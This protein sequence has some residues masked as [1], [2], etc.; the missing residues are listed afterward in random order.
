MKSQPSISLKVVKASKATSPASNSQCRAKTAAVSPSRVRTRGAKAQ[1]RAVAARTVVRT[2]TILRT[3]LLRH[4][5]R[6]S[7]V[8][9]PRMAQRTIRPATAKVA[10]IS[11]MPRTKS[12]EGPK[13]GK[14]AG[15]KGAGD[16][17]SKSPPRGGDD[18]EQKGGDPDTERG[19]RRRRRRKKQRQQGVARAP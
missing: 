18:P 17:E 3:A 16:E 15:S 6:R 7:R 13:Q 5:V 9:S 1:P 4:R 12:A 14:G 11:R 10:L 8:R 2:A 19:S